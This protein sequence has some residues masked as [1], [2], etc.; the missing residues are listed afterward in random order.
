[1]ADPKVENKVT[2]PG[3][4]VT[5]NSQSTPIKDTTQQVATGSIPNRASI[6][7]SIMNDVENNI[8]VT[9]TDKFIDSKFPFKDQAAQIFKHLKKGGFYKGGRWAKAPS[10][11][12]LEKDYYTFL[13]KRAEN[14][15]LKYTD[16]HK[17][18]KLV[19]HSKW[20]PV[21]SRIP[22]TGEKYAA[23]IRPDILSLIASE[24]EDKHWQTLQEKIKKKLVSERPSVGIVSVI[25]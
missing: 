23:S 25:I 5:G 10:D 6:I 9:E 16:I 18:L 14:I 12:A 11:N 22:E 8:F 7:E 17:H 13:I 20:V 1:M 24:R 4:S 21:E 15:R 3:R 2:A 19:F